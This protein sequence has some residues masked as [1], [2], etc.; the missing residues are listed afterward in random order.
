MKSKALVSL[1]ISAVALSTFAFARD[2]QDK[3]E[4]AEQA[5]Q[6][7]LKL[8]DSGDYAKSW[9]EASSSFK[10]AVTQ[11]EWEQKLKAVRAPL[12]AVVS[13]Q[14]HSAEYTTQLPGMPDGEYVV[15]RYDTK[16]V[17]KKSGTETIVPALDKDGQWRVSGYFIK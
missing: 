10:A 2:N 6:S 14:L 1:L 15:I 13:R 7:W 8:M 5:A 9:S 16:F 4:A 12:G 3:K 17:Q 11:A